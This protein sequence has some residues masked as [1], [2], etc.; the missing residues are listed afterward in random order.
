MRR[1]LILA[2]LLLAIGAGPGARAQ[3]FQNG[4]LEVINELP[5]VQNDTGS[6]ILT[7]PATGLL[8]WNLSIAYS[9]LVFEDL[10]PASFSS[11][12]STSLDFSDP[13][14]LGLPNPVD[15]SFFPE[16]PVQT[17][18]PA[19]RAMLAADSNK[20]FEIP[21]GNPEFHQVNLAVF[22]D[23]PFD[24]LQGENLLTVAFKARGNAPLGETKV[25]FAGT[26]FD[27]DFNE[28]VLSTTV[29]TSI[30]AVPEPHTWALMLCGI[31]A[32]FGWARRRRSAALRSRSTAT[33]VA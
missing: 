10:G 5:A 14:V 23:A 7:L 17:L 24:L 9:S 15:L 25:F 27:P 21:P 16:S 11:G 12:Y 30:A 28:T 22:H 18:D 6:V 33:L 20:Q 31:G 26:Y 2:G 19:D 1:F 13:L 29:S 32:L 4:F 8:G 3:S